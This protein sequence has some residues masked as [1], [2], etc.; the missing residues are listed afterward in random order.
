MDVGEQTRFF[1]ASENLNF[2]VVAAGAKQVAAI[3]CDVEM[4][5]MATRRLIAHFREFSR[6]YID[7]ENGD[8]VGLEAIA[9]IEEFPVGTQVNVA[10]ATPLN[11]V[12]NDG[13]N[14]FEPT[15]AITE[16]ADFSRQFTD[17]VGK[18]PV[19]TENEVTRTRT[20]GDLGGDAIG[21][22]RRSTQAI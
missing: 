2:V 3:R 7:G 21:D 6:A 18:A 14:L 5:R 15:V 8:S 4:A 16:H 1:V 11:A 22:D 12:G 10:A 13:L 19:A 9:R 20:G 17:E